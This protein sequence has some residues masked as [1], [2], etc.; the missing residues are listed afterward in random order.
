MD[1]GRKGERKTFFVKQGRSIFRKWTSYAYKGWKKKHG[2]KT[3][4]MV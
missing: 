2:E 3:K 4:N 1:K